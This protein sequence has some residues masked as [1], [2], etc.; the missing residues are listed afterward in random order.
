MDLPKEE[1]WSFVVAD[2]KTTQNCELRIGRLAGSTVIL[3][4]WIQTALMERGE[5]YT[6]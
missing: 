6:K 4:G 1:T 2:V 3:P 5:K